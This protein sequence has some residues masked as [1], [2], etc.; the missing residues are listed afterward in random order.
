MSE[1]GDCVT[2]MEPTGG[3]IADGKV[4]ELATL[5]RPV[6]T[7]ACSVPEIILGRR[8]Y[9]LGRGRGVCGHRERP[10]SNPGLGSGNPASRA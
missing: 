9:S 1:S 7:L 8:P 5:R 10:C 2:G 4:L 6:V 3:A